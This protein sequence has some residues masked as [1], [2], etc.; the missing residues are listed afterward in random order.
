[1]YASTPTRE[2]V[3][4]DQLAS[5]GT[6]LKR[7]L[8]LGRSTVGTIGHRAAWNWAEE[9]CRELGAVVSILDQTEPVVVAAVA[10]VVGE[11]EGGKPRPRKEER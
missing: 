5:V 1:M 10:R 7:A 6:K 4:R 9:A 8:E 2:V 11:R 3:K